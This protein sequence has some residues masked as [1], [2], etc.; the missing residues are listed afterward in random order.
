MLIFVFGFFLLQKSVD[1]KALIQNVYQDNTPIVGWAWN[2]AMGWIALSCA[3]DFDGDGEPDGNYA[4]GTGSCAS[5]SPWGL[6]MT[7]MPNVDHDNDPATPS[8]DLDY[9]KGCAWAGSTALEPDE[10]GNLPAGSNYTTPGWICFSDPDSGGTNAPKNGVLMSNATVDVSY[11]QCTMVT[12]TCESGSLN[13]GSCSSSNYC[14]SGN[15]CNT[16]TKECQISHSSCNDDNDCGNPCVANTCLVSGG[17]CNN[18]DDCE[19][20]CENDADQYFLLKGV[21]FDNSPKQTAVL[22]DFRGHKPPFDDITAVDPAMT[23][24]YLDK[25][26]SSGAECVF[27][28][29]SLDSSAL[30][31]GV[32]YDISSDDPT[33]PAKNCAYD[34]DCGDRDLFYC[35]LNAPLSWLDVPNSCDVNICKEGYEPYNYTNSPTEYINALN[36]YGSDNEGYASIVKM[37]SVTTTNGYSQANRL[38]FPIKFYIDNAT[39]LSTQITHD[40]DN[41]N[42]ATSTNNPLRGC[43]NC[44]REKTYK[45]A[46]SGGSCICDQS[47]NSCSDFTQNGCIDNTDICVVDDLLST[48]ENCQEYFYYSANSSTCQLQPDTTCTTDAQC[49]GFI[50]GDK[51]IAHQAG[52]L[53]KVLSGFNCTDCTIENLANSC[54]LNASGLNN[55][56]CSKCEIDDG[57]G[58][59]STLY[60]DGGVIYDNQ[61]GLSSASTLCGWGYNAWSSASGNRG[62][63]WVN[64]S[65]RIS[66][67]TKPYFSVDKGNIY[68]KNRIVTRYQ[69]PINKYNASYL[70]ESGGTITNF[71]SEV[72]KTEKYQG[73]LE[74]RPLINF[75][76]NLGSTKYTNA[77]GKLDYTGLITV[78]KTVGLV[79]YNKYGGAIEEKTVGSNNYANNDIFNNPFNNQVFHVTGV[80]FNLGYGVKFGDGTDLVV[81]CGDASSS[82]GA[83][84][85]VVEGSMKI[86]NDIRYESCVI[87]NLKKIPSLVWIV[88]G[89]VSVDSDVTEIAGT[90]IV[91]G[92]GST[93]CPASGCGR[94][95]STT[96]STPIDDD[97][98]LKVKGSVLARQFVLGRV[99]VNT[100]GDPAERFINDGRLQSNPPLG[101]TDMSRVIPRFSSY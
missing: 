20:A 41:P 100:D 56:R 84:I 1:T 18:D 8:V 49:N 27:P 43:F 52:D 79:D 36:P 9:I 74:S 82:S 15:S 4:L 7:I 45:C 31:T 48:C 75:L 99:S 69:P 19:F 28:Q 17:S 81:K 39:I 11:C 62:F 21:C 30:G 95:K 58:I 78:A 72:S 10:D 59:K 38:G 73:E 60:R 87:D 93:A 40:D 89:D 37:E 63:G 94:F 42:L 96:A 46:T 83:G 44:Y 91:L 47:V 101:L 12:G 61:H 90:F 85:I 97:K 6:K 34:F 16:I 29:A 50:T 66:T 71:V 98:F 67:S 70:I 54:T 51:C 2:D 23:S 64:F 88:K 24:C 53:K 26:C 3:N 22:N 25:N 13:S 5:P 35:G 68:S 65:P 92:N 80:P 32:C 86:E 57:S 33:F 55:N 77:L 76:S 14:S